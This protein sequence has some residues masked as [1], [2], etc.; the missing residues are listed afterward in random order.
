MKGLAACE[1]T[2]SEGEEKNSNMQGIRRGGGRRGRE[3]P[4]EGT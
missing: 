1:G 3:A 2:G 4:R